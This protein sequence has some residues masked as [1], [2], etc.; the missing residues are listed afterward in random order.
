MIFIVYDSNGDIQ[1][2]RVEMVTKLEIH[3]RRSKGSQG[4]IT[5]SWSLYQN[6]SSN[7]LNFIQPT[8]GKVSMTDGQWN[9]SFILNVDNEMEAPENV[10]WIQLENPTGGA[11][12]ASRDKTTVKILVAS[13]LRT[14]HSK[15]ISKWTSVVA[16]S[17]VAGVIVLMIVSCGIYKRR[18]KRKR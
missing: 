14:Q 16:G 13:N 2:F 3:V 17:C 8:S 1:V 10:I 5:V 4:N 15:K 6:D 7:S 11:L 12:L 18:T 9:E